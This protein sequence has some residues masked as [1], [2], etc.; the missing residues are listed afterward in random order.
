MNFTTLLMAWF[1]DNQRELPWKEYNDAYSIWV[2]EIILQQTRVQQ[3]KMYF[4]RFLEAF[5]TIDS[6]AQAPEDQVL[7]TW[8]GLGYYSRARYMHKTAKKI[9]REYGG[10]FPNDT[11]S[12]EK[13]DGIGPYT[14][15]AIGSFAFGLPVAALDGNGYRI[16]ARYFGIDIPVDT[17]QAKRSFATLAQSLL[18]AGDSASFNQALMD[19]GSLICTPRPVCS[20]C[21]MADTCIAYRDGQTEMLPVKKEKTAVKTRYFHYLDIENGSITYI[22][23][24]TGNDIW[25]GLYEFPLVET[26]LPAGYPELIQ[27]KAFQKILD[28]SSCTLINIYRSKP[29]KLSHQIIYPV[30]YKILSPV[31]GKHLKEEYLEIDRKD[32]SQYA[33]SRLIE[34]YM[35]FFPNFAGL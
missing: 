15:A 8:Q 21:P 4:H 5:P 29:H 9:M 7:K 33:V 22:R 6:L 11:R 19:F 27:T 23:Q 20:I 35:D 24:R 16:L 3:G 32:L 18:P 30:F 2:S 17:L 34:K 13:L 10:S 14:A 12:L 25:K 1:T 26:S 28:I 31:T